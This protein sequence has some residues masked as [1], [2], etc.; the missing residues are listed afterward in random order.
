[1][2]PLAF[3][4]RISKDLGRP[5]RP[6]HPGAGFPYSDMCSLSPVTALSRPVTT[7]DDV[8]RGRLTCGS[9]VSFGTTDDICCAL[10][11]DTQCFIYT[12]DSSRA[13]RPRCSPSRSLGIP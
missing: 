5:R 8:T 11:A 2:P 1:M 3:V 7:P 10:I 6:L 13:E 4:I 9:E 12:P